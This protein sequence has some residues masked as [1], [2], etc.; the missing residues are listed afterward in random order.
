M[1]LPVHVIDARRA[2]HRA[3]KALAQSLGRPPSEQEVADACAMTVEK[4]EQHSG[5]LQPQLVSLDSGSDESHKILELVRDPGAPGIDEAIIRENTH[6]RVRELLHKLNAIERD[7]IRRRFGLGDDSDQT[8]DEIG[9]TY[10]LSR[11]RVRQIQAQG[12]AKLQRMC[13]RR[14]I[15]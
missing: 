6:A 3:R 5:S 12:L 10:G 4:V 14:D 1:R 13:E 2:V 7:I 9:R 15:R 11:E 8:L